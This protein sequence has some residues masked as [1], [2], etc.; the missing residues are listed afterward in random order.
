MVSAFGSWSWDGSLDMAITRWFILSSHFQILSLYIFDI[1]PPIGFRI[2][3]GLHPICW[4]PFGLIDSVLYH[5]EALQFYE[6]PFADSWSY[7]TAIAVVFRSLS[8]V[9]I[10][11][12]LFPTFFS[13]SLRVSGFMWSSLIHLDLS[14]VQGGENGSICIL[15]YPNQQLSQ[16]H[17]LKMLSAFHWMVLAPLT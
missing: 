16:H 17:F 9:P 5:T 8:P 2:G 11:L 7:S 6:F 14:F 12:R 13:I 1:S 10:Y 4:L 15:L 3:K